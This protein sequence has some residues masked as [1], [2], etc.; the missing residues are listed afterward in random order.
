VQR[1]LA[2]SE[3]STARSFERISTDSPVR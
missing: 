1:R 3:G 2:H